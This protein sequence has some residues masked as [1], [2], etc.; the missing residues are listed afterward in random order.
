V[1]VVEEQH[2]DAVTP[3]VRSCSSFSSVISSFVARITSPVFG[4]FTSCAATR[5]STSSGAIGICSMPACSIC[6]SAARV[7]LRPS[8][9]MSSF[10]DGCRR[11]RLA[12]TPTR[13]S[14]TKR[15]AALRPSR[16]IVSLR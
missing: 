15:F 14:G 11:S 16:M 7:N 8:F 2:L 6:R 9:R 12:F 4:S 13:W 5:P 1:R 10:E 3:R